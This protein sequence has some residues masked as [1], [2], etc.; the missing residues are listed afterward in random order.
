MTYESKIYL[1]RF[2]FCKCFPLRFLN[3][4]WFFHTVTCFQQ[5]PV[6]QCLHPIVL[7]FSLRYIYFWWKLS[8]VDYMYMGIGPEFKLAKSVKLQE[9][10]KFNG[11]TPYMYSWWKL[12]HR[13]L[14]YMES[15]LFNIIFN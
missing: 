11:F 1:D 4:H 8:Y 3:H 5:G 14:T 6:K 10:V 15:M 7:I 13:V 12:F 9:I 2:I